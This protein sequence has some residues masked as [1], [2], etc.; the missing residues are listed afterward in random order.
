MITKGIILAGGSGTRLYPATLAISK[1]LLPV[2][3]KPMIYYP[4]TI[5]MLAGIRDVL[6]ISTPHDLPQFETLLRDGS[7]W[8]IN[9]SYAV[10][11]HPEGLPQAYTIAREFLNGEPSAMILGD[12]II[13]GARLS[14]PLLQACEK[15]KGATIFTYQTREPERFGIINLDKKQVPVS[16]EEKPK[17]P[18]SNNAITGL[19]FFD[20]RASD[21]AADLKPSARG[22]TEITDM[23]RFYMEEKTLG[24]AQLG[25]GYFWLDAGLHDSMLE[26]SKFVAMIERHQRFKVGCP[27]EVAWRQEWIT[28]DE[29]LKIAHGPLV[30]SGY[31][32][33]LEE[34]IN[35]FIHSGKRNRV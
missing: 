34:I 23:I 3:D 27:E 7:Q 22:E 5:L 16:I 10:Q 6:I 18:K 21:I 35:D 12:N 28:D 20:E 26:S 14:A 33:Y 25:R 8:G 31:G 15:P 4:L 29:L 24:V 30:K 1:Q 32:Q 9:L 13:Y 17:N 2:Y 11:E 19:Y